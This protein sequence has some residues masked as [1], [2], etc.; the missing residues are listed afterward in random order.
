MK[1]VGAGLA[2]ISSSNVFASENKSRPNI[3][4]LMTD[5]HR[6]DCL[7][8]MGNK[9]IKTPNL[10]RIAREGALFL[11]AYSS[12]PT[13]TPARAAL[14]TGLS[15]WHHGMIGFGQVAERY[16]FEM[17]RALN[18]A[19]YYT[20]AIGKLHYHP[21]RNYHGFQGA[22]L[23]ES[24]RVFSPDFISDYR[25]WFKEKAPDLNPDATG[26]GWNDYRS[27]IYA[28]PEELHPTRWTGDQA[29]NFI[30]NYRRDEPFMLKVSFARPHSPYDPPKRFWESYNEDDMP[31]PYIGDWAAKFGEK[32]N[33][34]NYTLWYGDLGIEQV[35]RSR[36]GYYGSIS[37]IDEQVGRILK[38]LEKR[39]MMENTLILFTS[40]HGDMQGDHYHWRKSYPYE[41]SAAV[42]ML[43]RWPESLGIAT[44]RGIRLT[45]V[46]E[47]RD[48]LPTF[49]DAAGATI[50][51]NLDGHSLLELIRG[52]ANSWREYLD[53]EHDVCYSPTNNWYA[54]TDG[55]WKYIFNGFDGSQELFDLKED[56]GEEHNL[57]ND[58]AYSRTLK[59]WRHRLI[60][61][62]SERDE[63]FVANGDLVL[64]KEKILYGPNYPTK[65]QNE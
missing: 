47:L 12:T 33:P 65:P 5:Q 8:C 17:P 50:P 57:A 6:W 28:L 29:V 40:D 54:L 21:Q 56:P 62:L 44:K 1:L 49:L 2:A 42:P 55:R 35:R 26:I 22:L 23:D 31:A 15:P 13:C 27:G 61:H 38:A 43:I 52:N 3:L 41:G 53:L 16:A 34:K 48:V 37:F 9:A 32:A 24:G 4:F 10:D 45:Q 58:P 63:R 20:F 30:E 18:D 14:L 19:G 64:R 36:R 7:G 59:F 25:K 46:V 60:K 11:N 51:N 39:G